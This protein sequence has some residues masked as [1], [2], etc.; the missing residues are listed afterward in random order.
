M[1][2]C[3]FSISNTFYDRGI[4]ITVFWL[5]L[6]Y[7]CGIGRCKILKTCVLQPHSRKNEIIFDLELKQLKIDCS[8]NLNQ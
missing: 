2:Y 1:L 5:S 4:V 7:V 3:K 6:I 8:S